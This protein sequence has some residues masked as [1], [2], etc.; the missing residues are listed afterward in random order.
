VKFPHVRRDKRDTGR[1]EDHDDF[2]FEAAG[3]SVWPL[4]HSIDLTTGDFDSD[5]RTDRFERL[6]WARDALTLM[7]R[8]FFS[9]SHDAVIRIYIKRAM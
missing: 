2:N 1:G 7:L 3:H 8:K 9:R 4:T 6:S 5:G